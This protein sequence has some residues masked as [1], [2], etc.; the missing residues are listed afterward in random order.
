MYDARTRPNSAAMARRFR[1]RRRCRAAA[2]HAERR[3]TQRAQL[4]ATCA[5]APN[6]EPDAL[7]G[8]RVP[9]ALSALLADERDAAGSPAN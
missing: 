8:R 5:A 7:A 1:S 2:R 9:R 3:R 4:V 6:R